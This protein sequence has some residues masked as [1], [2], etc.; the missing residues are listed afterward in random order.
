MNGEKNTR[1]TCNVILTENTEDVETPQNS[2]TTVMLLQTPMIVVSV[3][4]NHLTLYPGSSTYKGAVDQKVQ[5]P[6]FS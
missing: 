2:R 3:K 4:R 6:G 5:N 1:L